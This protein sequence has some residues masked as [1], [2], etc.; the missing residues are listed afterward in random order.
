MSMQDLYRHTCLD[1]AAISIKMFSKHVEGCRDAWLY[2][3]PQKLD[4]GMALRRQDM[5]YKDSTSIPTPMSFLV[6]HI[7]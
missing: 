1:Y 4:A 6:P 5:L 7:I 3:K 2:L